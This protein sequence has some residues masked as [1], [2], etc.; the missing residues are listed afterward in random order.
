MDFI[1]SSKKAHR[2]G[3]PATW[4]RTVD[5]AMTDQREQ[6]T[7]GET[8]I[9]RKA[10][11]FHIYFTKQTRIFNKLTKTPCTKLLKSDS[12]KSNKKNGGTA[13]EKVYF[14]VSIGTCS[15]F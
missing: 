11:V 6:L 1:V 3:A 9:Q 12:I 7:L 14:N 4:R 13:N 5:R 8:Q 2:Q 10:R 15:L